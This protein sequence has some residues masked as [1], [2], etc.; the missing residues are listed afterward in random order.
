MSASAYGRNII[1]SGV[2]HI[3]LT[4]CMLPKTRLFSGYMSHMFYFSYEK[5]LLLRLLKGV[6]Y[7]R[8]ALDIQMIHGTC[9][10]SDRRDTSVRHRLGEIVRMVAD[11]Q[12]RQQ[13]HMS[14]LD[15]PMGRDGA[16]E[17]HYEDIIRSAVAGVAAPHCSP[18]GSP[19]LESAPSEARQIVLHSRPCRNYSRGIL[20]ALLTVLVL[21]ALLFVLSGAVY[22]R[23]L[24]IDWQR[25][26]AVPQS[27]VLTRSLS[28]TSTTS[29]NDTVATGVSNIRSV[30]A[31]T[32]FPV[33]L[34]PV[35]L[36][37]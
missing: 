29:W 13:G 33:R 31:V 7:G 28:L 6:I 35:S 23:S 4:A 10:I 3:E 12:R 11:R 15:S 5:G 9:D 17:M 21:Q 26:H 34:D 8:P 2:V 36:T 32:P 16:G 1:S 27:G 20:F 24:I 19:S 14:G 22:A 37:N 30:L 18:V 25:V